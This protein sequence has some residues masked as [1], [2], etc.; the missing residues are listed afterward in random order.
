[1]KRIKYIVLIAIF[2]LTAVVPCTG[3]IAA[4]AFSDVPE[5]HW[6][7]EEIAA[8]TE[9]GVIDGMGE[10]LFAPDAPVTREQFMKLLILSAG[11][12]VH[13]P[14]YLGDDIAR[15][16]DVVYFE[17]TVPNSWSA[18]YIYTALLNGIVKYSDY[19]PQRV[20][21]DYGKR[22][23]FFFCPT[24]PISREEAARYMVR[25]LALT[26]GEV[27][28]FGDADDIVYAD[29]A[30]KTVKAGLLNGYEDNTFRPQGLTT[31]AEMAAVMSRVIGYANG[32]PTPKK[33]IEREM[34]IITDIS[35]GVL[36]AERVVPYTIHLDEWREYRDGDE[37]VMTDA[38]FF[39]EREVFTV[40]DYDFGERGL[41]NE[42]GYFAIV[43]RPFNR[44]VMAFYGYAGGE[45]LIFRKTGERFTISIDD[46]FRYIN[47][48]IDGG[49]NW[50]EV[51]NLAEYEE[52]RQSESGMGMYCPILI[53]MVD[54]KALI[55][56]NIT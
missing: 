21:D 31:R 22:D 33:V 43:A 40:G 2:L 7:Y 24:E 53:Y 15:Y 9:S 44:Y 14:E 28:T 55:A 10:G 38:V 16:L 52:L 47:A 1:M 35:G 36:T 34:C 30:A 25:A 6:A 51:L 39:S 13:A 19:Q 12:D 54:G 46:E 17:D 29:E 32:T 18:L 3:A 41:Y 4:S 50:K 8:L 37:F 27:L 11:I 23:E 26:G 48:Y 45:T 20:E 56:H 5:T 49:A 42:G